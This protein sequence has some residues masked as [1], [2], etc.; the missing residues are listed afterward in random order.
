MS[1]ANSIV[2]FSTFAK[3]LQNFFNFQGWRIEFS[4]Y[5]HCGVYFTIPKVAI[6]FESRGQCVDILCHF[7]KI[8]LSNEIRQRIR[9]ANKLYD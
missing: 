4:I 5:G 2:E 7:D 8:N 1:L 6:W 9:F 3:F